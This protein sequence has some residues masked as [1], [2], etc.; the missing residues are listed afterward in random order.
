MVLGYARMF[1]DYRM[2]WLVTK[3]LRFEL[4]VK[5]SVLIDCQ[6]N[7]LKCEINYSDHFSQ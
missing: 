2:E 6:L 5:R 4:H 3:T 1:F 7:K